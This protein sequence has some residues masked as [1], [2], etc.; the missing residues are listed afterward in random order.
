MGSWSFGFG[1]EK[2]RMRLLWIWGSEKGRVTGSRV[3]VG[4]GG[5]VVSVVPVEWE[6]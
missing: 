1:L 6:V 3:I 5:M 4:G 2:D